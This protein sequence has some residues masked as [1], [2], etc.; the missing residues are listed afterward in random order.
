MRFSV[1]S[2][3]YEHIRKFCFSKKFETYFREVVCVWSSFPKKERRKHELN[4]SYKY[5]LTF[6]FVIFF[7]WIFEKFDYS[8][9]FWHFG[10]IVYNKFLFRISDSDSLY[11]TV[12]RNIV[13]KFV[14]TF[15]DIVSK[16]VP[17]V[18][19]IFV[20]TIVLRCWVF[21][22]PKWS[23]YVDVASLA[24]LTLFNMIYHDLMLS[25]MM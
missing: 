16:D 11:L 12:Y 8:N 3:I 2:S 4:K 18:W 9:V 10:C 17:E 14:L 23:P 21:F 24:D 15:C 25:N 22:G 5:K 20:R 7:F 19:T 1:F 13:L 6:V